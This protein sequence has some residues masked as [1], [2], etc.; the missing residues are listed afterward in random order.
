MTTNSIPQPGLAGTLPV[1]M[2]SLKVS[3]QTPVPTQVI[4]DRPRTKRPKN[5]DVIGERYGRLVITSEAEP[6]IQ[7]S[8]YR[9][10]RVAC[11]CDCGTQDVVV[12]LSSLRTGNTTSCGCVNREAIRKAHTTHGQTRNYAETPNYRLWQGVRRRTVS[13]TAPGIE[14]YMGRGITMYEP[15]IDNFS[16][17]DSW[18]TTNLGPCPENQSLDRINNDGNYEPGNLRWADAETQANNT[19]KNVHLTHRGETLTV[20]Q[21]ARRMKVNYLV[22]WQRIYTYGWEVERAIETP[23]KPQRKAKL[24]FQGESLTVSQWAC[25]LGIPRDTLHKR[26]YKYGWSVDAALTT[27]IRESINGRHR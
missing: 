20:A 18:I 11:R 14:R 21:W 25:K 12:H 24:Q 17:F 5:M 8:G 16:A 7:P 27:P 1:L 23:V 9:R 4:S 19:S 26:I 15:W 6:I 2:T 3:N 10:R 13:G 22:I